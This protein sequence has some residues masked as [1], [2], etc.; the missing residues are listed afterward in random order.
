[1]NSARSHLQTAVNTHLQTN[2]ID[3]NSFQ[4]E[5]SVAESYLSIDEP[6][7]YQQTFSSFVT[8]TNILSRQELPE[9]YIIEFVKL[10][11]E[12]AE[13]KPTDTTSEYRQRVRW[14]TDEIPVQPTSGDRV[15]E[16]SPWGAV[17]SGH[18][19]SDQ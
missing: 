13:I 7:E 8:L 2:S 1:M 10:A 15:R 12:L 5:L 6:E 14:L 19:E 11:E 4:S 3:L 9:E 17:A 16:D 18:L